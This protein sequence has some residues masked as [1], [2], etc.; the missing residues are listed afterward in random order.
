LSERALEFRCGEAHER[1]YIAREARAFAARAGLSRRA[2]SE[3][4][5]GVA[6]LV[7][8][9]ARHAGGDGYVRLRV[10]EV[11][12][13]CIELLVHDGGP[14]IGDFVS[15]LRDGFS[16]GRQRPANEPPGS[17]E[18]L[19]VGLGAVAR[20][21]DEITLVSEAGPGTTIRAIKRLGRRR[22]R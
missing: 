18:S 10:L 8:N 2:C 15:A 17:A 20:L 21:M 4:G 14:G 6:E 11:P 3:L 9:V 16:R 22:S 5:I 13:P 1:F 19:G 12:E 7:S